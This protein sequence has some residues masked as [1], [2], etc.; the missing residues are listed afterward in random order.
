MASCQR[1]GR[2]AP[3]PTGIRHVV[4]IVK[5]NRTFDEMFGDV[6]SAANGPVAGVAAL[7]RF[8]LDA[9]V[10]PDRRSIPPPPV[11]KNVEVSPNHHALAA[12][13]AFS[14]NFYTD[15]EV[16]VDGHHWLVGSYPNAWTESSLMAATAEGE[17]N[18]VFPRPRP[19]RL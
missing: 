10:A 12:R 8:G 1:H 16:S 2:P 7:A 19:G 9:T 6:A 15:S 5:E 18:F 14:D 3:L 4:L 13:Y 17:K 11:L